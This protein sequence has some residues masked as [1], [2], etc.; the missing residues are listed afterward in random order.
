MEDHYFEVWQCNF[1]FGQKEIIVRVI[2][3]WQLEVNDAIVSIC[4]EGVN[5]IKLLFLEGKDSEPFSHCYMKL[6]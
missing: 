3:E 2:F 5:S 6:V 1:S 4:L